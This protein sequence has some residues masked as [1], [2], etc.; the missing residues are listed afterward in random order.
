M[1]KWEYAVTF[2]SN[3]NPPETIRGVVEETDSGAPS[4]AAGRAVRQA[5]KHKPTRSRYESVV[6]LLVKKTF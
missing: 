5:E 3:V 1:T 4:G 6:V 2:E